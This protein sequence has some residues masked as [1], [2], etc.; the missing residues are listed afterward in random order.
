MIGKSNGNRMQLNEMGDGEVMVSRQASDMTESER[1]GRC[2]Q[3]QGEEATVVRNT[4]D[5]AV[6]CECEFSSGRW[7][8]RKVDDAYVT[9]TF[10]A[11]RDE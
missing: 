6:T 8:R 1:R 4:R 11:Q 5:G 3:V 2:E 9:E 7:S 10:A